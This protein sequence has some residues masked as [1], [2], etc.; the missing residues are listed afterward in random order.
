MNTK[1][2][3]NNQ[4]QQTEPDEKH[5]GGKHIF[6]FLGIGLVILVLIKVLLDK[7]MN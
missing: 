1:M 7:L 5:S 2:S 6:I 4:N 3:V